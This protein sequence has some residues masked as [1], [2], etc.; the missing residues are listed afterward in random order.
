MY[1]A[2]VLSGDKKLQKVFIDK[3]D[4]HSSI[5]KQV[6]RLPCAVEEV[7]KLYAAERQAAKAISFGINL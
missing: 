6:F 1:Y 7:K 4:F 2:A 5:A 3:G